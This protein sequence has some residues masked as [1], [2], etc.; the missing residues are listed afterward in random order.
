MPEAKH[1]D[2]H[3]KPA[4]H[5]VT[6][7]NRLLGLR[8]LRATVDGA[9]AVDFALYLRAL[10]W[11]GRAIG[12][13]LAMA[14]AV[15]LAMTAFAGPLSDRIG[16][17]GLMLGYHAVLALAAILALAANNITLVAAT[18]LA[19]YGR[20]A[21][22]AAGPFGPV[23]QA[24]L[25][26]LTPPEARRRQ[27]ARNSAVGFL[28]MA[29]GGL[30]ATVTPMRMVF[31]AAFLTS[32]AGG[33]IVAALPDV[34]RRAAA[35]RPPPASPSE[36]R[37]LR[38]LA[39]ANGLLGIGTGLTGPLLAYWFAVRFG[40]G[41]RSIGPVIAASFLAAAAASVLAARLAERLGTLPVVIGMRLAGLGMLLAL[42]FAPG[43]AA[44]AALTILRSL[45]NRGTNGARQAL[46]IGLGGE[47]RMGWAASLNA[48]SLAV[49]RIAGP[50][51]A[52]AL[53]AAGHDRIPFLLA[54]LFQAGY[55]AVYAWSF[56]DE[57]GARPA[58]R[59]Q[60]PGGAAIQNAG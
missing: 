50:A 40:H 27:F 2:R 60:P 5:A 36:R 33:A 52:G 58:Q 48:L 41:P 8:L 16:R 17:R 14:L 44:A 51:I 39:F 13:L 15:G 21:N 34:T 4:A 1:D 6:P 18:L 59:P 3:A 9:L 31:V 12:G 22:G 56:R 57:P 49:P 7:A 29:A 37:K 11:D 23:E 47:A 26:D 38:R 30:V 24:W 53:I 10:G 46:S 43:F 55:L 54:A 32:L 45:C 42:P 25:A 28:G 35:W 19:Q 20:G